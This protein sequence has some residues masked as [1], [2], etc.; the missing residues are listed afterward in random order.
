[1]EQYS[2]DVMEK[3]WWKGSPGT[4]VRPFRSSDRIDLAVCCHGDFLFKVYGFHGG[5]T[6]YDHLGNVTHSVIVVEAKTYCTT[7]DEIYFKNT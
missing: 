3:W 2:L 6:L 5:W 7:C 4:S 1:M